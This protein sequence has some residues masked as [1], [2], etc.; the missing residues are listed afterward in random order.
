MLFA[1]AGGMPNPVG[2]MRAALMMLELLDE[3]QTAT[4]PVAASEAALAA[5]VRAR[6]LGV[7][8]STEEFTQIVLRHW[9]HAG[10]TSQHALRTAD[11]RAG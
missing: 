11:W 9:G 8:A 2:Q 5:G 3:G 10:A 4:V 1:G 7:T 6:D